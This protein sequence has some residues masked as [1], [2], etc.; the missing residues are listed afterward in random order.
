MIARIIDVTIENTMPMQMFI[1]K[2]SP[3]TG[4]N[5]GNEIY[6]LRFKKIGN[7][8]SK[9][10]FKEYCK[11]YGQNIDEKS[12][13]WIKE[14]KMWLDSIQEISDEN[15]RFATIGVSKSIK[16]IEQRKKSKC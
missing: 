9:I 15:Y 8:I 5:I 1:S 12:K 13:S 4:L 10:L 6:N 2:I 3:T 7:E 11:N 14:S 16:L